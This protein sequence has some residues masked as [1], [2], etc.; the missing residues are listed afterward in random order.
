MRH[1]PTVS[2]EAAALHDALFG[3]TVPA[4]DYGDASSRELAEAIA[5]IV[6]AQRSFGIAARDNNQAR[7]RHK[8]AWRGRA[9]RPA[10]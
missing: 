4:D 6:V 8:P 3:G 2:A 9:C 7:G 1:E 10:F 5:R